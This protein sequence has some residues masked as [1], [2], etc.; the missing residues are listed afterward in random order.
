MADVLS[1]VCEIGTIVCRVPTKYRYIIDEMYNVVCPSNFIKE[2][3]ALKEAHNCSFNC[4][5][6]TV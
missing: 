3:K 4:V 6:L 2:I 1:T 5:S